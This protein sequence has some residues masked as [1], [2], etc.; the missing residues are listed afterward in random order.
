MRWYQRR[1]SLTSQRSSSLSYTRSYL[2]PSELDL[3]GAHCLRLG[4]FPTSAELSKRRFR[5]DFHWRRFGIPVGAT[6]HENNWMDTH[7]QS[8]PYARY[9]CSILPHAR[10]EDST[11][12][13]SGYGRH[14]STYLS[15]LLYKHHSD[16]SDLS[17]TIHLI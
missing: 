17:G 8:S 6:Q 11:C 1:A 15:K 16:H 10:C 5:V 3:P 7:R 14:P 12:V 4:N 2:A 9:P 13:K